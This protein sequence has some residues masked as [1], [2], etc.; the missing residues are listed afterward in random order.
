[1]N[2]LLTLALGLA[3][4]T[5]AG[6]AESLPVGSAPKALES[7]WFTPPRGTPC[8]FPIACAA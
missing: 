6:T 8:E 7:P 3:L 2:G 1:M 5:A 4:G